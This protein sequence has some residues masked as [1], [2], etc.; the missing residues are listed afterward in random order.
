MGKGYNGFLKE[1]GVTNCGHR[2]YITA[3]IMYAL[4]VVMFGL[5]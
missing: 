4:G 2:D 5:Q 1:L 3:Y